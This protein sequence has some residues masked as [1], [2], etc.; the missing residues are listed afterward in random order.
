MVADWL[1]L[2]SAGDPNSCS[3]GWVIFK[4]V[5]SFSF[6]ALSVALSGFRF[7]LSKRSVLCATAGACGRVAAGVRGGAL[8]R[9]PDSATAVVCVGMFA[10]RTAV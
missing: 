8:R 7:C 1:C 5:Y 3:L 6:S 9:F 4:T 2:K 10:G